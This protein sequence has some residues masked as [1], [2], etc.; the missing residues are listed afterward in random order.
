MKKKEIDIDSE[1]IDKYPNVKKALS[2]FN[3]CVLH[4]QRKNAL[5]FAKLAIEK[6]IKPE[7]KKA[8]DINHYYLEKE[9]L[10]RFFKSMVIP[11]GFEV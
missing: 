1:L 6:D 5:T 10:F 2:V 4:C 11:G 8:E 7:S 3:S 9:H